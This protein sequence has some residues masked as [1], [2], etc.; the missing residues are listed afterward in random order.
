MSF[1]GRVEGN[2][3]FAALLPLLFVGYQFAAE[4]RKMQKLIFV[5]A[6]IFIP[7]ILLMRLYLAWDFLPPKWNIHLEWHHNTEWAAAI[8]RKAGNRPVAFMNSYQLPSKY[9]FYSGKKSFSLNNAMGRQ[10]QFTIWD[11][12]FE[13]QRKEILLVNNYP[14][15][16]TIFTGRSTVYYTIVRELYSYN[17]IEITPSIS[18][19]TLQPGDTARL[20]FR[21]RYVNSNYR[22][23][24][25]LPA[26]TMGYQIR[27][28]KKFIGRFSNKV[29][30]T[31][32]MILNEAEEH[33]LLVQAPPLPGKY[34]LSVG[35]FSEGFPLWQNHNEIELVV[36]ACE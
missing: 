23:F 36:E 22:N 35:L 7:L 25:T 18:E 26:V 15:G 21:M 27:Q 34:V 2:W 24:N 20:S 9:E 33:S 6:A 31:A 8:A 1:R 28:G 14:R 29:P 16:D 13:Y 10:N 3:I 12:E 4:N 19:I 30:V 32:N 11:S 17:N 5:Q